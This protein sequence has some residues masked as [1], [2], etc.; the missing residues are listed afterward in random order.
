MVA[1]CY[2]LRQ[3]GKTPAYPT[4]LIARLAADEDCR[5]IVLTAR[6]DCLVLGLSIEDVWVVLQDL[7]GPA[8]H[9]YKTMVSEKRPEDIFDVYD[10]FI[11]NLPIYLK[12]KVTTGPSGRQHVVVVV[13]FKRNEHYA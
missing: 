4:E 11:D 2:H 8:C 1:L 6:R 12:F 7:D 13:S 3:V 5:A 9:F 10:V